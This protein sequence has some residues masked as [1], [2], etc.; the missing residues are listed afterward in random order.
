MANEIF[1][2]FVRIANLA[3]MVLEAMNEKDH[4]P[5]H[6]LG[7]EIAEAYPEF[8]T[9]SLNRQIPLLYEEWRNTKPNE[10]GY[11]TPSQYIAVKLIE[12]L[13]IAKQ[14]AAV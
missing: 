5:N 10:S 4:D 2:N 11:L 6:S 8:N 1:T 12:K 9:R 7:R 13:P 14:K 3:T